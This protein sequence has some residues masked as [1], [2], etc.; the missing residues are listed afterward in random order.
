MVNWPENQTRITF[1]TDE[2]ES[3]L[4]Y[5]STLYDM[6]TNL[7]I[8]KLQGVRKKQG[9]K[10]GGVGSRDGD[11]RSLRELVKYLTSAAEKI[12][13][14]RISSGSSDSSDVAVGFNAVRDE[15]FLRRHR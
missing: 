11:D 15:Q 13:R 1:L 3:L 14:R 5:K 6:Y 8:L 9:A 12:R 2:I 7:F 4:N 10:I